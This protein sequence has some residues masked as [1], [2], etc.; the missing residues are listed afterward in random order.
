M[1]LTHRMPTAAIALLL[2]A[3]VACAQTS[4]SAPVDA[5][6][7]DNAPAKNELTAD[8]VLERSRAAVSRVESY[9]FTG[10]WVLVANNATR[11]WIRSGEWAAPDRYRLRFEGIDQ[12][13]GQGQE[14]LV[15]GDDGYFR[16]AGREH[17]VEL[18]VSPS[19]RSDASGV[20]IPELSEAR[21]LDGAQ[22]DEH[23]LFYLTGTAGGASEGGPTTAYWVSIRAADYLPEEVIVETPGVRFDDAAGAV[24]V[25]PTQVQRL[26]VRYHDFG[27][28]V[29]IERPSQIK[30][31][32]DTG[33]V[34][35]V[36]STSG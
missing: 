28:P 22:P 5:S 12:T 13:A 32:P 19:T 31:D 33:R 8:Q 27:T 4:A 1:A 30:N 7:Q 6:A 11:R 26:V 21:F 3:M 35:K 34:S 24:R 14:L 2:M 9:R 17:W 16:P 15:I 20:A 23:G 36:G 10:E 18:D 25:D 29:T